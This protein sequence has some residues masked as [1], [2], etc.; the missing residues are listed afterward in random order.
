[1]LRTNYWGVLS[2][3]FINEKTGSESLENL[4]SITELIRKGA[5]FPNQMCLEFTSVLI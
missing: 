1:M 5:G 3:Y 4:L 2:H